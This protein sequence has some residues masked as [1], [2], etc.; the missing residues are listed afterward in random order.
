MSFAESEVIDEGDASA[1]AHG[2][3]F[4]EQS[5][6]K[7]VYG[8]VL[9]DGLEYLAMH[10]VS[11]I[12]TLV[13]ASIFW[14]IATRSLWH[15]RSRHYSAIGVTPLQW[16]IGAFT[17][18][19]FTACGSIAAALLYGTQERWFMMLFALG[20]LLADVVISVIIVVSIMRRES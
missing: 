4:T 20:V 8:S 5:L 1:F 16:S 3:T 19:F 17:A 15:H 9:H 11:R 18:I 10:H 2:T 13:I 6:D 7:Q 12:S 14:L